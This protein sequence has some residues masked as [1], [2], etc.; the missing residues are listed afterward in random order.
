M[1]QNFC[2]VAKKVTERKAII[3]FTFKLQIRKTI[4]LLKH[5]EFDHEDDIVVWTTA[6]PLIIRVHIREDGAEASQSIKDDTSPREFPSAD[7]LAYSSLI[8]KLKKLLI[9]KGSIRE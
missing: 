8:A 5:E 2:R 9:E 4:P 3:C 1:I 7:I 6:F